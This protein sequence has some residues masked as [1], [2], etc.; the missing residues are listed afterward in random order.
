MNRHL[1]I[2]FA[3]IVA[4][5]QLLS[6]LPSNP[7]NAKTGAPGEG[8]CSDCHSTDNPDNLQGD[9]IISGIPETITP[10]TTYS[11]TI[12][13][14]KESNLASDAGFQ[15]T[16]LKSPENTFVGVVEN[17]SA[18]STIEEQSNRFYHEHAPA[19]DFG[20][21]T[22][23][24]WSA[25]WTS[26]GAFEE[27]A[28][29][30]FYAAGILGNGGDGDN[31][32]LPLNT[33]FSTVLQGTGNPVFSASIDNVSNVTCNGDNDGSATA[34]T[35]N[36]TA[37]F[38][39]IWSNGANTATITDLSAGNYSV[40][41]SD[42]FMNTATA[43]IFIS[44]PP[45]LSGFISNQTDITC[46]N[47]EGSATINP[48]GGTPGY[49]FLWSNGETNSTAT[50]LPAGTNLVTITD[51]N[52]CIAI[53]QVIIEEDFLTPIA[54]AGPDQSFTCT[55]TSLFLAGSAQSCPNCSFSWST[56][57]GNIV[58]GQDNI[59]AI[60]DAPGTYV[61]TVTNGNNGCVDQ[62][63][64]MILDDTDA[65]DLF[66]ETPNTINCNNATV[67]IQAISDCEN[68][69]YSWITPNGNIVGNP[70]ASQITVNLPGDYIVTINDNLTGCV[71]TDMVQVAEVLP[72][73][74]N[75][76]EI[77]NPL[78]NGSSDGSISVFSE[79]GE[80]PFS[81]EWSSGGMSATENNLEAGLY[82]LTLTDGNECQVIEEFLLEEPTPLI[83]NISATNETSFEANDGTAIVIPIGGTPPYQIEWSNGAVS[84][85]LFNLPPDNYSVTITDQNECSS[86]AVVTISSFDCALTFSTIISDVSCNGFSDGAATIQLTGAE[87]PI[88][89]S[90]SNGSTDS[91][92]TNLSAGSYEV[93]IIDASNCEIITNVVINE[94]P[95]LLTTLDTILPVSCFDGADGAALISVIGG[96]PPYT[97][98]WS[99]GQN[100]DTL[101][102]VSAG[103]Y[104]LTVIDNQLCEEVFTLSIP[105]PDPL[106]I[107]VSTTDETALNANDGT[108]GVSVGGGTSPYSYLWSNG[109][110]TAFIENLTPGTYTVTT[111]DNN[112]CNTVNTIEIIA[113]TCPPLNVIADFTPLICNDT[114]TGSISIQ[115]VT[116]AIPP[117]DYLW[118]DGSMFPVISEIGEGTYSVTIAD[119]LGC[120]LIESFEIENFPAI[121]IDIDEIIPAINNEDGA[122]SITISGSTTGL[123]F[124]WFLEEQ[125]VSV[126]EDPQGL[127]TG[128]YT[129]IVTDENGCSA[130]EMVTV[131][132][133][134]AT[135][136]PSDL[137]AYQVFPNPTSGNLNISVNGKTANP[138]NIEIWDV[139]GNKILFIP[140]DAQTSFLESIDLGNMAA[141]L[142][143]IKLQ[144]GRAMITEKIVLKR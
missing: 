104:T 111:T 53:E 65:P 16:V 58:S 89:F 108:A 41:I 33:Q 43:S 4:A 31:G 90:W 36:G 82:T 81:F 127:S 35:T 51:N 124:E 39:Y 109:E 136:E 98:N 70:N 135:E 11:V 71:V 85:S 92:A 10:N 40:T 13:I 106:E 102:D 68:C 38:S 122:I 56:G 99:N 120:E 140:F 74:L 29:I 20:S 34:V 131:E 118:S 93:T 54:N 52:S 84:D 17:P 14:T 47:G 138:L 15:W 134:I 62:D 45:A 76:V 94:P 24:S 60:V 78:C 72:V 26:P 3:A 46:I 83:I 105:E 114:N 129:L 18:S 44:E 22:S 130:T 21:Q 121:Q 69:V 37:P 116:G 23:V 32:D 107:T 12:T 50:D 63:V 139:Q 141:G 55:T 64:V 28:T 9:I 95:I 75:S 19:S 119:A 142:Y 97:L 103:D 86:E 61:L 42:N 110:E 113:F 49:S 123:S 132:L 7:P 73:S 67:N 57:N 25:D 79:N 128:T 117:L 77:I 27:N 144:F 125:I 87:T 48:F 59:V 6:F 66:I 91:T 5:I 112:G 101:I 133:I 2:Y 143:I 115:E 8:L 126:E 80:E 30:T 137:L 96:T 100:G 88:N 1:I